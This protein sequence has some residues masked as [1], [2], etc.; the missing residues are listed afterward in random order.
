MANGKEQRDGQDLSR[1]DF[2]KVVKALAGGAVLAGY[3]RNWKPG[4]DA[5][6][7]PLPDPNSAAK[8]FLLIADV[9]AAPYD[10]GDRQT[11]NKSLDTLNNVVSHLRGYPFDRVLQMGDL[12][13]EQFFG[14]E[15]RKNYE[16]CV[17]VLQQFPAPV[18]NL[19]GNHDLWAI[20][21]QDLSALF[22]KRNLNEFYGVETFDTFQIAW[23]DV[24]APPNVHGTLPPERIDWLK[25]IIYKDTPTF[26][27]THYPLLPQNVDGN[28]YFNGDTGQSA[29]TN[30]IDA[31]KALDGLPVPAIVSAHLHWGSHSRVGNT[32]MITVPAFVE[33]IAAHD[34]DE[35]P[36]IYSVMEIT[37][38]T[39]FTLKS[40]FGSACFMRFETGTKI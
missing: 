31:W 23:L 19:L 32:D 28:V 38:P 13:N 4:I 40:F 37:D 11:N 16:A 35:N 8:R 7:Q 20:P 34:A 10:S 9:H 30:G 36:G 39:Q 5:W 27:F 18:L 2:F 22:R 21:K 15:N 12:I 26:I 24:D 14:S 25:Q 1:A 33:N 17:D 6:K 3:T 29:Y